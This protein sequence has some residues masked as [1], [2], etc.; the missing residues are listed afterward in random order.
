M[1]NKNKK[2]IFLFILGMLIAFLVSYLRK[3]FFSYDSP[4]NDLKICLA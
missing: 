1:N 2:G 4:D 3:F